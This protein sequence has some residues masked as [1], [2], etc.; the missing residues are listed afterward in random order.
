MKPNV[1]TYKLLACCELFSVNIW[2]V[3][4]SLRSHLYVKLLS[5]A[6]N[7]N[8]QQQRNND[9]MYGKYID[10]GTVMK[11]RRQMWN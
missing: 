10:G 6:N 5:I 9:E 8:Q 3:L 11:M 7:K 4:Q 2:Q 1:T